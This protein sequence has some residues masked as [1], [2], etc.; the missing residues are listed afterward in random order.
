MYHLIDGF[1][2]ICLAWGAYKGFRKGFVRQSF[3]IIAAGVGLWGGFMLSG[4]V[5]P[6]L[7]RYVG[8]LAC[9]VVS[10]IIVFVSIIILIVLSGKLITLFI[11]AIALGLLNRLLGALFGIFINLLILS[12]IIMFV[13][14]FN[15]YHAFLPPD[16][17]EKSWMY[18]PVGK[19]AEAIF[20]MISIT[21]NTKSFSQQCKYPTTK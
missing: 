17:N 13:N 6:Y 1:I 20:P 9:S 15:H 8:Q 19:V 18:R 2:L 3:A 12:V 10:F 5:E 11:N 21:K 7:S 14:R 4:T 16:V